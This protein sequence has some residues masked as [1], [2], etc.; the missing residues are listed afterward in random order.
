MARFRELLDV[1]LPDVAAV[2]QVVGVLRFNR[3]IEMPVSIT[4]GRRRGDERFE[5]LTGRRPVIEA[6]IARVAE[7]G[8]RRGDPPW[9]GGQGA[10]RSRRR[11][12]GPGTSPRWPTRQARC[13]CRIWWSTPE[14]CAR[15]WVSG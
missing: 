3:M 15:C 10:R 13:W 6:A 5:Q 8:T 1:E 14:A 4:G 12:A 7:R 9:R 2:L 11:P